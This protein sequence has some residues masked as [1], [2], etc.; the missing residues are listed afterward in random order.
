MTEE[1]KLIKHITYKTYYNISYYISNY[2]RVKLVTE[3]GEEIL[4]IGKGLTYQPNKE[5]TSCELRI[6]GVSG[7]LYHLV[8]NNFMYKRPKNFQIHHKDFNHFNN[9]LDNLECLSPKEHGLR[10]KGMYDINMLNEPLQLSMHHHEYV[11]IWKEHIAYI[12]S[13]LDD[14]YVE[15]INNNKK[16]RLELKKQK[17][18][19]QIENR[20]KKIESGEYHIGAN[21]RIYKNTN[22]KIKGTKWTEERRKKTME[23]RKDMYNDEW[24]RKVSIGT[25]DAMTDDVRLKISVNNVYHREEGEILKKQQSEK[26]KN[27]WND[28]AFRE[29]QI[30]SMNKNNKN[31]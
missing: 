19:Q 6:I 17:A 9:R 10:H 21:N 14:M 26:M 3:L 5:K 13:K 18:L 2:G 24:R 27:L 11:N 20:R 16:E 15:R 22:D 7:T 4:E 28:K 29:K 31:K 8:W 25:K 30:K 23:S 12:K 1:W